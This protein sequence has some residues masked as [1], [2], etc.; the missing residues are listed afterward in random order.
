MTVGRPRRA[1]G[2]ARVHLGRHD[3][4]VEPDGA[5]DPDRGAAHR[6]RGR[7]GGHPADRRR[8]GIPD[9]CSSLRRPRSA[10]WRRGEAWTPSFEDEDVLAGL[11]RRIRRRDAPGRHC[12]W[13]PATRR[14]ASRARSCSCSCRCSDGLGVRRTGRDDRPAGAALG[15]RGRDRRARRLDRGRWSSGSDG[16]VTGPVHFSPGPLPIGSGMGDASRNASCSERSPSRRG[17]ACVSPRS[18]APR[19]RSARRAR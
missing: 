1:P 9:R 4:G 17:R 3:A 5:P 7:R 13:H 6:A 12:S 8:S 16:Q 18:G 14:H 11:P 15:G 10:R 19:R 2:P